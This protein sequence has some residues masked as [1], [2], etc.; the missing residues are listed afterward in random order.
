M[1]GDRGKQRNPGEPEEGAEKRAE[2]GSLG[3]KEGLGA[4]RGEPK[5]QGELE[6]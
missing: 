3:C 1:E 4:E 2:S 5:G 6:K